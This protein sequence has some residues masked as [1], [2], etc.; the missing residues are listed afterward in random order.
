MSSIKQ[1]IKSA[2]GYSGTKLTEIATAL[3]ISSSNLTQRMDKGKFTKRELVEIANVIGCKY[4]GYFRFEHG[5]TIDAPIHGQQIKDALA[6]RE[7]TIEELA[8][9][10]GL[11]RQAVSSRIAL[12]KIN[13]EDLET[14]AGYLGCDYISEFEFEDGTVI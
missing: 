5:K 1:R 14:I 7:M 8:A 12:S 10:M 6:Y 4:R 11:T 9:K 2:C 3:G 13:Q